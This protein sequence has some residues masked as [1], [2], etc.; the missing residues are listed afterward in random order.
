[1]LA[2]AYSGCDYTWA[3]VWLSAAVAMNGSV[4]TGPL[5]SMVDISPNY[6]SKYREWHR[7]KFVAYLKK[8]QEDC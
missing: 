4:S 3:V 6:A 5:A 8:C 2:L 7:N 1:M